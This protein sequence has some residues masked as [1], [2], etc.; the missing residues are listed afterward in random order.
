MKSFTLLF[1]SLILTACGCSRQYNNHTEKVIKLTD[2]VS[3]NLIESFSRMEVKIPVGKQNLAD[4]AYQ[5]M[6]PTKPGVYKYEFT[7][8]P[9]WISGINQG[10]ISRG[11]NVRVLVVPDKEWDREGFGTIK[12]ASWCLK[13][14]NEKTEIYFSF[15]PYESLIAPAE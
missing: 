15:G 4:Y 10:L 1:L 8:N 2:E 13:L 6:V 11:S 12:G 9:D 5:W 7:P 14:K 3:V